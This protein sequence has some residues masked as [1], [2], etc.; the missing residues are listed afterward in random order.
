MGISRPSP[1][2]PEGRSGRAGRAPL[3][4]DGLPSRLPPRAGLTLLAALAAVTAL[5]W[6]YLLATAAGWTEMSGMGGMA[7]AEP[8][9]RPWGLADFVLTFVMWAVMMVG[10]MLP[11]V[12]P[13]LSAFARIGHDRAARGRSAVAPAIFAAGYLL[14]WAG[15]SAAATLAQWALD[16]AMLLSPEMASASLWLS[17]GVLIAAGLYQLSPLKLACLRQCRTPLAF[18]LTRWREGAGGAL[19]MG[20]EH[21]ALCLG[22]CWALMALLFVAGVM[23]LL[24]VAAIAAFVL[25]EK[26]AP[27]GVMVARG[28][29]AALV[30]LGLIVAG[31]ALGWL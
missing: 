13:M 16:R 29:G 30:L 24:A 28:S 1:G 10:M 3:A 26:M 15:F 14:V 31:H 27:M 25:I 20:I 21:G 9:A 8:M 5:A 22:C 4:A 17:A 6:V 12:A 19:R 23:N 2:S 18:I 11:S 7:M